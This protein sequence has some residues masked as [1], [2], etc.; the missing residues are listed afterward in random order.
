MPGSSSQV[1]QQLCLFDDIPYQGL[2]DLENGMT[3][4]PPGAA[5]I[6]GAFVARLKMCY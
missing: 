5:E 6:E 2:P 3:S 4:K 1:N